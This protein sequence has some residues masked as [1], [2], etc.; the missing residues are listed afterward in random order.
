MVFSIHSTTPEK[1]SKI[2]S[3]LETIRGGKGLWRWA[4]FYHDGSITTLGF[5]FLLVESCCF[6]WWL[7]W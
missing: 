5:N 6:A 4:K 7:S 2:S 3:V 1:P